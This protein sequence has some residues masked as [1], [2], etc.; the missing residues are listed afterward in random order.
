MKSNLFDGTKLEESASV[1]ASACLL[2]F[3]V[4]VCQKTIADRLVWLSERPIS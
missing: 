3:S 2:L 1:N 4:P